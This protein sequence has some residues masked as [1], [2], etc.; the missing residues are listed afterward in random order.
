MKMISNVAAGL[1]LAGLLG[2]QSGGRC[3]EC[4]L[5]ARNLALASAWLT[6]SFSSAEQAAAD[7]EAY[8]DIRLEVVRIW[9]ARADGPWIYVEQA[10]AK[11]LDRPYRQR[12]YQL[13]VRRDGTIESRV[14]ALPGDPLI[15]AGAWREP[16]R[17]AGLSPADLVLREGCTMYL[18]RQVDG[19]FMGGTI[20]QN[21]ESKLRGA[22]YA[23][24]EAVVRQH[25]L[26]T[27]DRGFDASGK[28][29]WGA[30]SGGYVFK[31]VN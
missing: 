26:I 9:K 7:P 13:A 12:V 24:S 18:Q 22:S 4:K 14:Y 30:T 28:Q 29:V 16:K 23:T 15:Y 1:L 8:L 21:C 27:W 31:R 6:G 25:E 19:A 10:S 11:R 20:G 5:R 2:C 3:A 17:F